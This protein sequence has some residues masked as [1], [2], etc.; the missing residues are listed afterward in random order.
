MTPH[1]QSPHDVGHYGFVC[2]LAHSAG[3]KVE[4]W[5]DQLRDGVVG[6]VVVIATQHPAGTDRAVDALRHH[7]ETGGKVIVLADP[8]LDTGPIARRLVPVVVGDEL[9]LPSDNPIVAQHVIAGTAVTPTRVHELC[10][11]GTVR[12][13]GG[14]PLVFVGK[15]VVGACFAVGEGEV[16]VI[17]DADLFTDANIARGDNV[18]F[19][20]D[21]VGA[22]ISDSAVAER[23]AGASLGIDKQ[24]WASVKTVDLRKQANRLEVAATELAATWTDL[25]SEDAITD[26]KGKTTALGSNVLSTIARFRGD[27][28]RPA[29]L[30]LTNAPFHE[31]GPTPSTPGRPTSGYNVAL[32]LILACANGEP[33]GYRQE[34]R[35]ALLHEL[36]PTQQDA[37]RQTSLSSDVE[38]LMH[39]ETAFHLHR[40]EAVVLSCLRGDPNG[41]AQTLVS[42]VPRALAQLSLTDITVLS[43]ARYRTSVDESFG[44]GRERLSLPFA[45][46]RG[47]TYDPLVTFDL[48][49][50]VAGDDTAARA[51]ARLNE[52]VLAER[53][54]VAL[55]A[56]EV[57][58]VANR[59][60]VH[61][62]TPFTARFDGT[63]RWLLRSMVVGQLPS[64]EFRRGR[65]ISTR[66]L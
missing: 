40:P 21:I 59:H 38:L 60:A 63:D 65:I 64:T 5:T 45:V 46:L 49:L 23:L 36:V 24:R 41:E 33:V 19:F 17:G 22:H 50:L 2:D 37:R 13:N 31:P 51:L 7:A 55:R 6:D 11:A 12:V 20:A 66:Y 32:A 3:V 44:G 25:T 53:V 8:D 62:R 26:A 27:G 54:G 4:V 18:A 9:L 48:D 58:V 35:G 47:S 29:A 57:L 28:P 15:D 1:R 52:A 39:I 10:L 43:E 56:R 61:G 16:V 34:G 42:S 14:R 30:H